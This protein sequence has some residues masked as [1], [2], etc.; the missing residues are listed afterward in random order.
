MLTYIKIK[1]KFL[2][3]TDIVFLHICEC[4]ILTQK[5]NRLVFWLTLMLSYLW[6]PQNIYDITKQYFMAALFM[7]TI[8]SDK[9]IA[10]PINLMPCK[11]NIIL[12]LS[13]YTT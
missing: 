2:T 8:I 7:I 3:C 10:T 9:S 5:F 4:L 6:K 12:Y 1:P 13:T 11:D